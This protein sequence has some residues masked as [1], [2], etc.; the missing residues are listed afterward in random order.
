MKNFQIRFPDKMH[1]ALKQIAKNKEQTMATTI[2]NII[3]EY[4]E[5]IKI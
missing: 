2:R 5:R 1:E 3:E 4:L